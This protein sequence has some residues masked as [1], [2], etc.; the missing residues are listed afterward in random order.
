MRT[1]RPALVL[2]LC[3]L[4]PASLSA[5]Q[6]TAPITPTTSDPQ[7]V[8][9]LQKSLAAMT[10]GL[11]V[12][13]VTL[14][15]S[16]RR[17]AGSDDESGTATLKADSAGDSLMDLNLPSGSWVEIRNHAAVPLPGALPFAPNLPASITQAAQP[18]G[19][20]SGPDGT[21]HAMVSHNTLTDAAWFFPAL[22]L[23]NLLGG[24]YVLSYVGQETLGTQTVLHVSGSQQLT[25]VS[26]LPTGISE[27]L[28]NLHRHVTQMDVFLDA[29][30]SLP[31]AL[32]FNTHPDG[33]ALLDIPVEVQ[34]S[35]YQQTGGIQVPLHVQKW[36][37]NTLVL[38]LQFT[39]TS[40]NSG[41]PAST[42]ALQ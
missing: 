8:A 14:A 36:L 19:A 18:A 5:Q 17:I 20:W 37:N 10:G 15:G 40:V 1:S 24:N 16:A 27:Q 21:K 33:N 34:L 41:V 12:T 11:P 32:A 25:A 30:T 4:I 13:D 39:N 28:M 31:V 7:A 23:A 2:L 42:F 26:N 9:L 6:L 38:D 35:N 22:T 3:V 29:T